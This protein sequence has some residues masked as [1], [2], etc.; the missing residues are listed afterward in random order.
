MINPS[1]FLYF[2]AFIVIICYMKPKK[3]CISKDQLTLSSF[4]ATPQPIHSQISDEA[5]LISE[6]DI[7]KSFRSIEN[8]IEVSQASTNPY[9]FVSTFSKGADHWELDRNKKLSDLEKQNLLLNHL[10]PDFNFAYP[11]GIKTH[12][13]VSENE[14]SSQGV[15]LS[16]S[17]LTGKNNAFKYSFEIQGVVCVPCALLPLLKYPII[18][19][20]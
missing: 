13:S 8:I 11:Y 1:L 18:V 17:H 4:F 12:K 9:D 20:N 19:V 14:K 6:M 15:Y 16:L 2:S 7:D 3:V 5:D 10:M